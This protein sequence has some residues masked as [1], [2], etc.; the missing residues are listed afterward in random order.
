M[1]ASVRGRISDMG[2]NEV[3]ILVGGIGLRVGVPK[4]VTTNYAIEDNILLHTFL[5]V[6]EDNLSLFGFE[7]KEQL[8][9]FQEL[10]R[11]NGVGP[12]LA[13]VIISTLSI[14]QIYQAVAGEQVHIFNQV[15]GIG[16]KTAQKIIFQLHDR[17]KSIIDAGGLSPVQD[18]NSDLM[19]ALTA[20]GYSVV[21]SQT[22]IQSIP[23]DAPEELEE[24]IRMALQ[25]FSS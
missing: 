19:D 24:R 16:T 15:P 10:L 22:A 7:H 23:K 1:I 21:E 13:L 12:R 17:M 8:E 6:R 9:I 14:N 4:S 25:Y 2:D 18:T 20:L 5:V 11:A 3:V